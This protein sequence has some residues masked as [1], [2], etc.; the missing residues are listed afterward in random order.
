[1]S[2]TVIEFMANEPGDRFFH[3]HLLYHLMSGMARV[4]K[5]EGVTADPATRSIRDE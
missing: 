2:T 3:R 4:V 5:Y 1:M